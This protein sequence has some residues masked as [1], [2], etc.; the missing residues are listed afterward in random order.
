MGGGEAGGGAG[1][2]ADHRTTAA[3]PPKLAV[4]ASLKKKAALFQRLADE[5]I[6][7]VH[8]DEDYIYPTLGETSRGT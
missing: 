4:K 7:K 2:G 6:N 3:L 1:E 8:Q 5:K